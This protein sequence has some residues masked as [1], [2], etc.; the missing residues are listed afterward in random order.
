MLLE[1]TPFFPLPVATSTASI[2]L[3]LFL[4]LVLLGQYFKLSS[5]VSG[6]IMTEESGI[7]PAAI[8]LGTTSVF[9]PPSLDG[10]KIFYLRSSTV[11]LLCSDADVFLNSSVS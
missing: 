2:T 5:H 10:F 1:K 8:P 7:S 9:L 3:I 11:S 6:F 4:F